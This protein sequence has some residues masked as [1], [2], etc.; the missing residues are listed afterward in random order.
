MTSSAAATSLS[1]HGSARPIVE[2]TAHELLALQERG[3][4]TAVA[5]A[6][7]FLTAAQQLEVH[8]RSFLWLD[9]EEVLRQA[10]AVDLRRRSG[11]PLG[12]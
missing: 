10:Q 12:P 7:A 6:E 5:I 9:A 8:L 3:E 4:L 2:M 1:S 11:Q